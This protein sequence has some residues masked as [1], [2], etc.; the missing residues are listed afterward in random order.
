MRRLKFQKLEIKLGN[1]NFEK[2]FKNGILKISK[3]NNNNDSE[4]IKNK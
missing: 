1:Q 3:Q 4:I 2:L